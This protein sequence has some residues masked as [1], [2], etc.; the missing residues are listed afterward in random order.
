[1]IEPFSN[2]IR[3][4]NP[5]GNEFWSS[6]VFARVFGYVNYRHFQAAAPAESEGSGINY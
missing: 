5:A 3:R 4:A 2:S 1:L 6:R